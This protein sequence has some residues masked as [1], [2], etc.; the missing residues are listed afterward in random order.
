MIE[1]QIIVICIWRTIFAA[2]SK[3]LIILFW[4]RMIKHRT[5]NLIGLKTRFTKLLIKLTGTS[6]FRTFNELKLVRVLVIELE[7][8][9]F[10]IKRSCIKLRTLSDPSLKLAFV[11]Y[12]GTHRNL[13]KKIAIFE[14]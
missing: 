4:H 12:A 13:L 3:K 14:C 6:F 10:G 11:Y 2:A 9:I 7:H 8:P 1:L 5:S